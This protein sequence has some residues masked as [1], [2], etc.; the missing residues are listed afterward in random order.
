MSAKNFRLFSS[1]SQ[2]DADYVHGLPNL[3][4]RRAPFFVRQ[5]ALKPYSRTSLKS[6]DNSL[7]CL[8]FF[9]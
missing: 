9:T 3:D 5:S 2:R 7:N 6:I 1:A 4:L 8:K